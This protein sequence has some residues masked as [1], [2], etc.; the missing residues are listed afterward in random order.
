MTGSRELVEE[1][2]N[3]PNHLQPWSASRASLDGWFQE[4]DAL[5]AEQREY[6]I[7]PSE[8]EELPDDGGRIQAVSATMAAS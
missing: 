2:V 1:R 7:S 6:S 4:V 8:C 5:L 3:R